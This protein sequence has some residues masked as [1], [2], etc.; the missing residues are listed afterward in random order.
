VYQ[1]EGLSF[2]IFI[3]EVDVVFPKRGEKNSNES[4]SSS[5][6]QNEFLQEWSGY[7]SVAG[8]ALLIGNK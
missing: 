3:D 6:V 7:M 8:S 5:K 2:V 1:N 4:T